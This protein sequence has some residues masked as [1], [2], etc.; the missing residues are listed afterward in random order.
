MEDNMKTF[1]KI[2]CSVLALG[3]VM[4]LTACAHKTFDHQKFID[5]CEEQDFNDCDDSDEFFEDYS[6]VITGSGSDSDDGSY[7][8]CD[9]KDAQEIYDVVINRF[10][11]FPDYD[12]EK[13]SSMA[14]CDGKGFGIACLFTCEEERDAEKL[15]KKLGKAY[16]EDGENGDEKGYS[17]YIDSFENSSGREWYTGVYLKGNT[18]L[19]IRALGV[20]DVF[21]ADLCEAF[22]V[23]SP[24]DL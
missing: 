20:D 5:F 13:S 18:V 10:G 14:F 23:I 6:R 24:T 12:M 22:D 4:G 15:F 21:V 3:L 8:S 9:G 19:Y 2:A 16:A 11:D 7:I 1:K 17:Y